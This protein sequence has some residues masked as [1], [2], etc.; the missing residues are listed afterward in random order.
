VTTPSTNRPGFTQVWNALIVDRRLNANA[1]RVAVYLA[2]FT[3]DWEIREANVCE[4]LGLGRDAYRQAMRQLNRAGYV[5]RGKTYRDARTGRLGS[6]P[7]TLNRALIVADPAKAQ[8]APKTGYQ[9]VGEPG[10]GNGTSAGRTSYSTP[11]DPTPDTQHEEGPSACGE[12]G[13]SPSACECGHPWPLSVDEP[14]M[15][16]HRTGSQH[17]RD[18]QAHGREA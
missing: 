9:H 13:K 6:E 1:V 8:V 12:D 18:L 3:P 15:S 10:T 16:W 7:S 14:Y 4:T 11:D 5:T 17:F 2:S